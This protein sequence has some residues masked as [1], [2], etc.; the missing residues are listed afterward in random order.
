MN[1][2]EVANAL[3]QFCREGKNFEAMNELYADD[4]VSQE[5]E[6]GYQEFTRGK[7]AV[8]EKSKQWHESVEEIHGGT[9]S[10]PIVT[11]NFFA[12]T[13]EMDITFKGMGRVNMQEI[14][15]Y[16]VKDGKIVYERFFYTVP[17]Q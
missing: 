7:E 11:G 6:G 1:T 9:I 15:V 10:D 14:C 13:M 12:V 8:L 5:Q 2:Q 4:I 17:G 3:V 16:E